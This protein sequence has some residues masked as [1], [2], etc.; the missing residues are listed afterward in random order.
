MNLPKLLRTGFLLLAVSLCHVI[1][2]QTAQEPES[3]REAKQKVTTANDKADTLEERR[4]ALATLEESTRLFLSSGETIEAARALNR[5]GR[6]QLDLNEPQK[7]IESHKKALAIL[8]QTPSS[9]AEV[10]NL[11]GLALAHMRLAELVQ[12][13]TIL[14]RAIKLSEES[15]YKAGEAEALLTLSDRQN[16]DNHLIALETA[17]KAL[18]IWKAS[19]DKLGIASAYTQIGQYYMALDRLAE[20]TQNYEAALAVWRDQKNAREQAG[21]LIALGF[22]EWRKADWQS[23]ISLLTKARS[24]L[25]EKADPLKMGQISIG[26]AE[27]FN[28]SGLPEI[29]LVH[30]QQGLDY[31]RQTHKPDFEAY[32]LFGLARTYYLLGNYVESEKQLGLVLDNELSKVSVQSAQCHE[33]LGRIFIA[34][35]EYDVARKHLEAAIAIY[36][37]TINPLELAQALGLMGQVY[38]QEGDLN[39]ARQ[40]YKQA[41][42]VF[43]RLSDRVNLAVIYFA[44]GRLELKQENLD[45]AESSLRQS[46]EVTENMRRA[47]SSS[48]LTA[49]FSATVSERYESYIDCLMRKHMAQPGQEFN[50]RAFET[51][52]QSRGRSLVELLHATQTAYAP[53]LDPQL[54]EQEKALRLSLRV[55][56]DSKVRLLAATYKKEQLDAID[57]EIAQLEAEYKLVLET[58]RTRYPSFEQINRPT[59]WDL[60][61]IQEKVVAD[62]ETLLLEYSLG[63]DRSYVWAVTRERITSHELPSQSVI[64]VAAQK[65]YKLLAATPSE[66]SVKELDLAAQELSQMVLSPV[67]ADLGRRR[68]LIVADGALNYIPFQ[69]L[70]SPI[71]DREQLLVAHEVINAPSASVLGQLRQEAVR[72]QPATTALAA[73]GDPVFDSNYAQRNGANGNDQI[74]YLQTPNNDRMRSAL[75]D[76]ELNG[77]SFDPSLIQ[78]LFYAKRELANLREVAGDETFLATGFDASREKLQ[79]TDLSKY[80]IVHFATHGVLDPKRPERSGLIFST[81]KR[82][83][84]NQ[85][86]FVGLSDIYNLHVP[87]DLVVLS[88]CRTGLGKDVRGEGLIGITRGFMYAG[89]SSV[90][91]S[92]WKVDDEATAEL[93]KNFYSNMLQHG[94]PPSAALRAAQNTIRQ[95]PQWRAPYY[96]AAFT[97]Q[98]EYRNVITPGRGKRVSVS[99]IAIA[100]AVLL[101]IVAGATWW[102][103][104]YE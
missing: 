12:A 16:Y 89:A 94:M 20:S 17:Q 11:N 82:D 54:A 91:A 26:L 84:K 88:A 7:A 32:A 42:D 86:G 34:K 9:E 14:R 18:A 29:G 43:T 79:E 55:K 47:S 39:R 15:A 59:G 81:I 72:R 98:G 76:I 6:L 95:Q 33:L 8:K 41:L 40:Y 56:E 50:V 46:I 64:N 53:G 27:A 22:I 1:A 103:R 52:E 99:Q 36:T 35:T 3:V 30:M 97:L 21:A 77:D 63:Q 51:S 38:Q 69:F 2:I 45:A 80:A 75:R 65:I 78:P 31:Y 67:A 92:L 68:I 93:M 83:G 57:G 85:E 44:L 71:A 62:N 49:A 73:F 100:G 28:E 48:D 101:L 60:R 24:F 25:E 102:Y 70:P 58:I 37:R 90:V 61:Q 87:A 19:D 96:W 4:A 104:S 23:S 13:E 74:A 10:D 66:K 5:V